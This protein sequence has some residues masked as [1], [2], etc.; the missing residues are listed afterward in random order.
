MENNI[1]KSETGFSFVDNTDSDFIKYYTRM[2]K[3]PYNLSKEEM[4][5]YSIM[6]NR[7][8]LSKYKAFDGDKRYLDESGDFFFTLERDQVVKF[9]GINKGKF[10]TLKKKLI[11]IGLLREVAKKSYTT[12]YYL[13]KEYDDYGGV[14]EVIESYEKARR[15]KELQ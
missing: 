2:M 5:L 6:H 3:P 10:P 8:T 15:T 12:K 1:V 4:E 7:W 9:M 11:E 13:L 14:K